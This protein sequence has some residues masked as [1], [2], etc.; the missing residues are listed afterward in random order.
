MLE[1]IKQEQE[2]EQ[3]EKAMKER[4]LKRKK[5]LENLKKAE[6]QV[7]ND[8]F[9]SEVEEGERRMKKIKEDIEKRKKGI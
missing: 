4:I 1:Y 6:E 7:I 8:K 3:A 9:L 5:E 2:A